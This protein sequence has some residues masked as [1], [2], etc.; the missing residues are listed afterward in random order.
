MQYTRVMSFFCIMMYQMY[1]SAQKRPRKKW[2]GY[3]FLRV[4]HSKQFQEDVLFLE[5]FAKSLVAKEIK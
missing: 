2:L 1:Q 5:M 4:F 3:S